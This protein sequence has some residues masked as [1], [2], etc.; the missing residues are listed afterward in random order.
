MR[1][2]CCQAMPYDGWLFRVRATLLS[3]TPRTFPCSHCG[4][5]FSVPKA[6]GRH[7][8]ECAKRR[9]RQHL[10]LNLKQ[11]RDLPQEPTG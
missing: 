8:V 2:R 4:T 11:W 5:Q 6:A 1:S 9:Q 7:S 3:Q 10:P